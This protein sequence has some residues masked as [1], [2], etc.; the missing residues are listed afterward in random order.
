MMSDITGDSIKSNK[1]N[2]G[3]NRKSPEVPSTCKMQMEAIP[4]R[5]HG[6]ARHVM[7]S[8]DDVRLLL[9]LRVDGVRKMLIFL[10]S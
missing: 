1:G 8:V 6:M 10:A 3:E 5:M 4:P 2:A 7:M 9:M